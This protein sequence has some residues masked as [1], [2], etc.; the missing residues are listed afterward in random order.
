MGEQ[1]E[2]SVGESNKTILLPN[3][4]VCSPHSL[5][6]RYLQSAHRRDKHSHIQSVPLIYVMLT[7]IARCTYT[8]CD[9]NSNVQSLPEPYLYVLTMQPL[10]RCNTLC[11]PDIR[12]GS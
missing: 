4:H 1:T 12:D 5:R 8:I 11:L 2:W 10:P 6:N 7:L 9:D 3:C